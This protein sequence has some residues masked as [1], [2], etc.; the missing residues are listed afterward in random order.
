MLSLL[1]NGQDV[2]PPLGNL[3]DR[4]VYFLLLTSREKK[5]RVVMEDLF[6]GVI[7][8]LVFT[9]HV[10]RTDLQVRSS[11]DKCLFFVKK[12]LTNRCGK[13]E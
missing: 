9:L 11:C 5:S 1:C 8:D 2:F 13:E 6:T 7:S 10:N 3:Q 12:T 4:G